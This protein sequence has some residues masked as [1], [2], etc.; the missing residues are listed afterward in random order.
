MESILLSLRRAGQDLLAPRMLTLAFWPMVLS[1]LAWGILA[2]LFGSAWKAEIAGFL[3]ATPLDDLARWLGAEWLTAYA[4]VFVLS[5]LWLP[6]MYVTALLITSLALMPIIVGFVARNHYP[7]LEYR[8]GGSLLGSVF[9]G[10]VAL[11]LYLAAWLVLLPLWLFA[12]FGIL[13]S[14][15]L[16]AWLNQKL[17]MYD[18]LAEHASAGELKDERHAGGWRLFA[19]SSL[20]GLLHFVPVVNF[21]APVYMAL[22]FTHHGLA[23]LERTRRGRPA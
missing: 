14:V 17:F 19:L 5:L 23:A 22:A 7:D 1:L 20:L 16:N 18:A 12:P 13:V 2:W 8:R 15:L 6:A 11:V 3:A 9:N 10:L 4:A 21:V